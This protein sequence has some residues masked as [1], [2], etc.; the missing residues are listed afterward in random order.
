MNFPI[1][2]LITF[3]PLLISVIVLII[4]KS[5]LDLIRWN[6]PAGW[7]LLLWPTLSALWVA[8]GGLPGWHLLAVFVLGTILMRSA[9]CCINDLAD[10]DFH[11]HVKRTAQEELR[12]SMDRLLVELQETARDINATIDTKMIALNRLIAEADRR[13]EALDAA[14]APADTPEAHTPQA[15]E[16][17]EVTPPPEPEPTSPEGI[18]RRALEREIYRLADEGK[19]ELE[20]ARLTDTPRG[21]VELVLSLR[22][23]SQ[24]DDA[25]E[26]HTS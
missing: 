13:L 7:L 14:G 21:E 16:Q 18:K 24:A 10:R 1:L 25:E 23:T 11:R 2:S 9:G 19:T 12:H 5:R 26:Q 6:R 20:I 15:E 17:Q 4:P 22:N 3:V 8:S